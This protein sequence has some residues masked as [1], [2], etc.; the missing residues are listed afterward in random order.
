MDRLSGKGYRIEYIRVSGGGSSD[1]NAHQIET[2]FRERAFPEHEK[3]VLIGYSKGTIDLLHF[4]VGNPDLL[5]E[6][7]TSFDIGITHSSADKRVSGTLTYFHNEFEDLIDF[8]STIFMMVNREGVNA[9]G[10]EMQ[11]DYSITEQV[12]LQL[13][14][15]YTNLSLKD[16]SDPLRQ[17]PDWRG[18]MSMRWAPSDQW[19]VDA[20]WLYVD[21]TFDSSIPTGDL[22][23]DDYH[24]VDVTVT[25]K[26]S[27]KLNL[28]LSVDNLLDNDY[29]EAI[30]FPS[31][32]IRAR[33]GLRYL[34]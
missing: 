7:S 22:F 3:L 4:L 2:Y 9:D 15:T 29:A 18:G 24:R 25:L 12:D 13:Q 28:M 1:Y 31:P 27:D 20:S 11:L 32:G 26:Q 34:F 21:K 19:L 10:V 33:V 6:T 16:S 23:L 5:P 30:G 17:R 8:D 14:A